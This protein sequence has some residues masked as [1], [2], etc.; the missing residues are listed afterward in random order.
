MTLAY[1]SLDNLTSTIDRNGQTVTNSYDDLLRVTAI[2]TPDNLLAFSYDAV[3]K[4]LNLTDN[5]S[6]LTFTYDGIN[7]LV[8]AATGSG[9]V[10]PVV[11]L[12]NTYNAVGN[13]IELTDDVGVPGGTT[14]FVHD[15]VGRLTMLTTS[16]GQTIDLAYDA[17]GRPT[18]I[19]YP[20]TVTS[21]RQYD[22][23][24]GL[25]SL[26]H[27]Q[28][29]T[30]LV[31]FAY[32]SDAL[33]NL[34]SIDEQVQVRNFAYDPLQR[35][36][37]GGTVG[38]PESYSYDAIGNRISSHLSASHVHDSA[39]RLIEDDSFTYIYD[40]N[41]NVL[42]KTEKSTNDVTSYTYNA[43]D[44]LIRIDFPDLTFATYR[45]DGFGR[46]TEKDANGAITRY[47]YDGANIFLEFDGGNTL[48][49]R[50]SHGQQV[51]QPLAV[52]RGGQSF[53]YH[54]DHQGSIRLVTDA[55][56]VVV[57]EYDYDAYGNFD[58]FIEGV[59]N[60][61]TYT[62]REFDAESGL[63]YYRARYYDAR[64]GRFITS[65][66]I[67]LAA[68]ANTYAYVLNNPANLVDP[69][70]LFGTTDFL[71][72]YI[73]GGGAPIDLA[74]VGLLGRFRN[75]ASVQAAIKDFQ[76][77]VT[78]KARS[79]AGGRCSSCGGPV[80]RSATFT[81]S[82]TT[83]VVSDRY[84]ASPLLSLGSSTFFRKAD[85]DLTANCSSMTFVVRCTLEFSI[86]DRFQDALDVF[87]VIPGDQDMPY[88][89]TYPIVANWT[90]S[91]TQGG[92]F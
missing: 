11:T 44:Q 4:L 54:A 49:A 92:T 6:D 65:D 48:V 3:G 5:D 36:T 20:N 17:A 9:G 72:H 58:I 89:T 31:N 37:A 26:T 30:E 73:N 1:D 2:T 53:F 69:S 66:P 68:G 25:S 71:D 57:N 13:R 16:A 42:T 91:F 41:G 77:K 83:T 76:A 51:D 80:M 81:L 62:G 63:Y 29:M 43:L 45:Y 90:E 78:S 34:V 79:K 22:L 70:G 39:N 60:P 55:A 19:T 38:A 46:R 56:G 86:N 85:C 84:L 74:T 7:R 21:T 35:L 27:S 28:G 59:V 18:D 82:V 15:A 10:Q 67:D 40:G 32:L 87:N 14:S 52:E 88:A 64:I 61:F 47:V 50:Y 8:T 24:G 75:Q 12:T 33:G 23:E